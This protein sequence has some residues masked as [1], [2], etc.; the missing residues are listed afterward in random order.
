MMKKTYSEIDKFY[1]N[2]MSHYSIDDK[3]EYLE[4][5]IDKNHTI[6]SGNKNELSKLKRL[7]LIETIEA[8]QKEI[9]ILVEQ[10]RKEQNQID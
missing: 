7:I 8:A 9:K 2:S 4:K 6:F 5:I 3:V 10:K 1:N